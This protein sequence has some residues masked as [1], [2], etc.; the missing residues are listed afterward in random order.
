MPGKF[1]ISKGGF[2]CQFKSTR[3]MKKLISIQSRSIN[4]FLRR[5]VVTLMNIEYLCKLEFKG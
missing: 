1:V 5:D 4:I 3:F 2:K